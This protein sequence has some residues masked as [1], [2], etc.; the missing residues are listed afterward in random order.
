M[1]PAPSP[2]SFD[3]CVLDT[4][5]P[6]LAELRNPVRVNVIDAQHPE[7]TDAEAF[8]RRVFERRYGADVRTFH[9]TLLSF[10]DHD[11]HR[12]VVGFRGGHDGALFSEQYLSS[13]APHMIADRLGIRIDRGEL[14]EV[15]HLALD[16]PGDTR[17]VIAAATQHLH[18]R[19]Y[20]WVLF[21]ATRALVNAFQRLG[22][23]P[24]ELATAQAS[25]LADGGSHW[26]D[27]Y[28]TKPVVC[29]GNID[30]GHRKLHRHIGPS[31]PW[32]RA[33]LRESRESADPEVSPCASTCG[34]A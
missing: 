17:W 15:G 10:R 13:P 34:G 2:S 9:P 11:R 27:Y 5:E 24:I 6:L 12:A 32:L 31:Q 22:L 1:S 16:K 21:T 14:V 18:A 28:R 3:P 25:R 30:S 33:L 26:G 7:R 8:V 23:H 20:R 4:V 19:G 29:V